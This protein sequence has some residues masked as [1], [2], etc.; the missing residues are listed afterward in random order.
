MDVQFGI[1]VPTRWFRSSYRV[2]GCYNHT[3]NKLTSHIARKYSLTQVYSHT[4][5][6]YLWPGGRPFLGSKN[7]CIQFGF[8]K[9]WPT[10]DSQI[11]NTQPAQ[12]DQ[13]NLVCPWFS[14]KQPQ[15][16][17]QPS[18]RNNHNLQWW[19]YF[20]FLPARSYFPFKR[21][22]E[23]AFWAWEWKG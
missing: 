5:C 3:A 6:C 16:Q 21:V 23:Y 18:S 11:I 22:G 14:V 20:Q 19:L 8:E 17:P 10:P 15:P 9:T 2:A 7:G 13:R 12:E 4:S 1:D